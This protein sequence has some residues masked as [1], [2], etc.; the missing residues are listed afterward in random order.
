M[1]VTSTLRARPGRR[2]SS[3]SAPSTPTAAGPPLVSRRSNQ[4]PARHPTPRSTGVVRILPPTPTGPVRTF[5]TSPALPALPS[6]GTQ[7]LTSSPVHHPCPPGPSGPACSCQPA[8]HRHP[9]R[10]TVAT[11]DHRRAR[12]ARPPTLTP[13]LDPDPDASRHH[14]INRRRAAR[15]RRPAFNFTSPFW[16]PAH[17][18]AW[19]TCHLDTSPSSSPS[20]GT[21]PPVVAQRRTRRRR[22]PDPDRRHRHFILVTEPSP[23]PA[24]PRAGTW[25]ARPSPAPPAPGRHLRITW[26]LSARQTDVS[27]P[28]LDLAAR[29]GRRRPPCPSQSSLLACPAWRAQGAA[30][31][32][33]APSRRRRRP[34]VRQT[35]L[36]ARRR[37]GRPEAS[38]FR[39]PGPPATSPSPVGHQGPSQANSRPGATTGAR[40]RGPGPAHRRRFVPAV[41]V[42][43]PVQGSNN[44]RQAPANQPGGRQQV[45]DTVP[46]PPGC[47]RPGSDRRHRAGPRVPVHRHRPRRHRRRRQSSALPHPSDPGPGPRRPRRDDVVDIGHRTSS[48][49]LIRRRRSSSSSPHPLVVVGPFAPPGPGPALAVGFDA[50]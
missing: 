36:P 24:P 49:I 5:R 34:V 9:A 25:A 8:P 19:T 13:R 10:P 39:G 16:P 7:T 1:T 50:P 38:S 46:R 3:S 28:R 12:F 14:A 31:L 29:P 43:P 21:R 6:P 2:L 32:P 11:P 40:R 20:L 44:P 35:S 45:A 33:P 15:R 17:R 27:P 48:G 47:R 23:A 42:P 4:G 22:R 26:A 37:P 30:R 41:V 18:P